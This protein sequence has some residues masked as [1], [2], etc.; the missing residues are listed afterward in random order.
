[1]LHV[2]A[3]NF[4]AEQLLFNHILMAGGHFNLIQW[5]NALCSICPFLAQ[6]FKHQ[7]HAMPAKQVIASMDGLPAL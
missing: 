7:P 6:A 4:H 3:D 1:M 5:L 2:H